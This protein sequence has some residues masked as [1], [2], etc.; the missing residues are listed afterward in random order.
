MVT[1][2]AD[3]LKEIIAEN[4]P[5]RTVV[6]KGRDARV[7]LT[8]AA[9]ALV[10]LTC[11]CFARSLTGYFL[12]DDF[13]EVAYVARIA[14]GQWDLIAA[15]WTGNYMQIPGM[16][17]YR[18]VFLMIILADY[19]VWHG[20]AVG[21]YITNLAYY[22]GDVLALFLVC[23]KL[24]CRWGFRRSLLTGF[25]AAA[26]FAVNPLHCE[27][28]SWMVGRVDICCAFFYLL[29]LWFYLDYR[30][31]RQTSRIIGSVTCFW[32]GMLVKEMAIGLP[33][34]VS[35]I[36]FLDVENA[37]A[38]SDSPSAT[39]DQTGKADRSS[40][41]L[42]ALALL[43]ERILQSLRESWPLWASTGIYFVVRYLALG[44]LTGGYTGAIGDGQA[45]SALQRWLDPETYGR[46]LMPFAI[47][48]W[49]PGNSWSTLLAVGYT[50][51]ATVVGIKLLARAA[52]WQIVLF[53]FAWLAT[54]ALPIYKLWGIGMDLEGARF[55]FFL[56]IAFSAGVALLTMVPQIDNRLSAE[57][58]AGRQR[59]ELS[60]TAAGC[61][62]IMLAVF[63]FYKTTLRTN[64][65]WV[66][67]GKEVRAT[68][69]SAVSLATNSG[70]SDKIIVLGIPKKNAGAH[71]IYNG[72]TFRTG[73]QPPFFDGN[74]SNKFLTFD[75]I[76]YGPDEYINSARLK[77]YLSAPNVKGPMVWNGEKMG[78]F[79]ATLPPAKADAGTA[80]GD[81]GPTD[82]TE[83]A[84]LSVDPRQFD[85]L[86]FEYRLPAGAQ[87][88]KPLLFQAHWRG[89]KTAAPHPQLAVAHR[90]VMP[91]TNGFQ[92]VRI[93]LS[94]FW[95]WYACGMIR[96]ISL[97]P[98]AVDGMEVRALR[99]VPDT[100]L[101]PAARLS[102]AVDDG[103]GVFAVRENTAL[104]CDAS[105]IP[106]AARILIECSKPDY[107]FDQVEEANQEQ[108]IYQRAIIDGSTFDGKLL[109]NLL[110]RHTYCEIRTR[111]LDAHG[112]PLGEYSEPIILFLN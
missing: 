25:L 105:K 103:S 86:E 48:L 63:S 88:S 13:G 9:L 73:L 77:E 104:H 52:R 83:L 4:K 60:L 87:L 17:V 84:N 64:A 16:A 46:V 81:I 78:F 98:P 62:A 5:T 80:L 30:A 49:A 37:V 92:T 3:H 42:S 72:A 27:S 41:R 10:A 56:T 34:L 47:S 26:L 32:L 79:D 18:P 11:A 22:I 97:I 53:V 35:A 112:N 28:V 7:W 20:Q 93:P 95:R 111:A 110:P 74:Y 40:T 24:T 85:F 21:Y 36:S 108:A 23:K 94:H 14:G 82:R 15:N 12:A 71:M 96:Q 99:L 89:S 102:G 6:R 39:G 91:N 55:C 59:L 76:F 65:S 75:P 31:C 45:G 2:A 69:Q 107:F 33:I 51:I 38:L 101:R 90:S 29:S 43:S 106:Q 67:A 100:T 54:A 57:G 66:H 109:A 58:D 68:L 70:A 19:L 8:G 61:V 50:S 1:Q 44:T